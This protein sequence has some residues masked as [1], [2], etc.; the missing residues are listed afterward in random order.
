MC[1]GTSVFFQLSGGEFLRDETLHG[2]A[3]RGATR[4]ETANP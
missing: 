1:W 3:V 2:L 4:T